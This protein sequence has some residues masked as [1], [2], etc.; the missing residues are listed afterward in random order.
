MTRNVVIIIFLFGVYFLLD[1]FSS[2]SQSIRIFPEILNLLPENAPLK[3]TFL[4]KKPKVIMLTSLHCATCIKTLRYL[5]KTLT[6]CDTQTYDF[7]ILGKCK[8]PT[9]SLMNYYCYE[10]N[11]DTTI[12]KI[13][14]FL[15]Y[16]TLGVQYTEQFPLYIVTD[17]KGN[18]ETYF[19]S[20]RKFLDW[21]KEKRCQ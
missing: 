9:S 5:E 1:T 11:P 7:I 8:S 17:K 3:K 10:K 6:P 15:S 4:K 16:K 14:A 13:S 2:P 21:L 19:D 12:V 20:S 18:L